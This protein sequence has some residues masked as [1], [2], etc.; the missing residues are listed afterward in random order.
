MFIYLIL[1]SILFAAALLIIYW[2]HNQA[3]LQIGTPPVSAP[4]NG[5]LVSIIVPARNEEKNIRRC[6]QALLDQDYPNFEVIVLDD[7]SSDATPRILAELA[8]GDPRLKV[9]AGAELPHGWAGK[10]HALHQASL[11]ARGDWLLFIDADTF[12]DPNALSASLHSAQ[13]TGADLYTIM[14]AQILGSFWEKVVMPLVM[15]ALSVGFS[16]SKVN[17]PKTRDAIANGQFIMIKRAVYDAIGGHAKLR[18]LIVEDKAIS[19][20]VK[21]NGY[22]LIVADGRGMARTRM[23][24]SLP[25]IWEGW[26]KNIYLGLADQPGL[27][28]LGVFGAFLALMAALGMPLWLVLGLI[29]LAA[30][31][32]W[33]AA[34]IFLQALLVWSFILYYRALVARHMGISRLYALSTPLGAGVFAA[35][36]LTSAWKVLSGQGVSWKGRR[37][38]P[39]VIR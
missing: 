17:D 30:G 9:L 21:R 19:E 15:T 5:T 7:R 36:M 12:L 18:N 29:W 32:G 4:A 26:T 23:Y 28:A 27:L 3:W 24:T 37:Y 39:K 16:P 20:Q 6:V 14:T 25:E 13:T 31:G 10:P 2:L 22:R 34:L 1:S 38:D 35:M 8:A 11:A 33:M